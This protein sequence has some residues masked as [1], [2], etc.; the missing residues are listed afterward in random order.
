MGLLDLRQ[1]AKADRKQELE[2]RFCALLNT[3]LQHE[4]AA[5]NCEADMFRVQGA[6]AEL[7]RPD[8][9]RPGIGESP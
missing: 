4:Q 2:A 3:K 8:P 9:P 1:A 6:L 7:D 5:K